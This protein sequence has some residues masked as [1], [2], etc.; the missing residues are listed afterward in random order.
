MSNVLQFK[1]QP[2]ASMMDEFHRQYA[3]AQDAERKSHNARLRAANLLKEMRSR[4][5]AGECG[6]ITWWKWFEDHS[7]RSRKDAEKLLAL[8]RSDDPEE[9][10]AAA[11]EAAERNREAQSRLRKRRSTT[12]AAKLEDSHLRAVAESYRQ[13]LEKLEAKTQ[14][15][16]EPEQTAEARKALYADVHEEP[17]EEGD[18]EE[19]RFNRSAQ[20]FLSDMIT[21]RAYWKKQFGDWQ[22]FKK[23]PTVIALMKDA[24][25]E[26]MALLCEDFPEVMREILRDS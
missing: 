24:H 15:P 3:I 16:A 25:A 12:P 2:L 1:D 11:E 5:E 19:D 14:A 9:Q 7:V 18:T 4:V 23:S 21:R 8:V 22:Q 13:R 26:W 17:A 20:N 6:D 10:E